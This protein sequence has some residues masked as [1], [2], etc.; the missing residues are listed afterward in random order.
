MPLLPVPISTEDI[1]EVSDVFSLEDPLLSDRFGVCACRKPSV[2][3]GG[4]C[5]VW[6]CILVSVLFVTGVVVFT[7][8]G[9]IRLEGI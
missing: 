8:M 6:S 4:F 1:A 2:G 7:G 5:L 9:V 3:L